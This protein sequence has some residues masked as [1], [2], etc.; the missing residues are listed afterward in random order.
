[1]TKY[2]LLI[3]VFGCA[4]I[5]KYR[6]QIEKIKTTWYRDDSKV[7]TLFFLSDQC[8]LDGD[9]FIG[10][11]V[12]DDYNSVNQKQYGGIHYM[13]KHYDYKFILVCGTDTFIVIERLL[14]YLY[15][16]DYTKELYIGGHGDYRMFGNLNLYYHSGGPGFLL[17]KP[18]VTRLFHLLPNAHN[19]WY[20]FCSH[21]NRLDLYFASDVSISYFV[22]YYTNSEI[23]KNNSFYH[24]N[25]KGIPCHMGEIDINTILCCHNMSLTDMDEMY[26]LIVRKIDSEKHI[27]ET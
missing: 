25:H 19:E 4:S 1:M 5:P 14:S 23:I 12:M 15:T 26:S 10:L 3:C 27:I 17:S 22:K 24:C 20:F 7:K 8:V 9:C 21:Y 18:C 2:E 11:D 16:L 6:Q 13:H